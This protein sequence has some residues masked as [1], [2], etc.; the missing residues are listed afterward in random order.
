MCIVAPQGAQ[1]GSAGAIILQACHL[2]GALPATSIGAATP[3][4][5]DGKEMNEDLRKKMI[6]D[7]SAW[8][9][10]LAKLRNRNINFAKEIVTEAKSLD[11]ENA[12][13]ENAIDFYKKTKAELIEA[14][15]GQVIKMGGDEE[16]TVQL[17]EIIYLEPGMRNQVL[18]LIS[19]PQF[20]YMIFMGSLALLYFEITHPGTLV[21]G[22]LGRSGSDFVNDCL[23]QVRSLLG[24]PSSYA[25][26]NYVSHWRG[27]YA[28][29]WSS[30]Y[31]WSCGFYTRKPFSL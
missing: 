30:W 15:D 24:W 29:F 6:N 22:V 28:E 27:S 2:T 21:P 3:V 23:S 11:G 20:A 8:V 18:D 26:G 12:A 5:G 14:F 7:T 17:G 25:F 1:A 9:E 19:D 10:G 16:V 31:R 4:L 13:K